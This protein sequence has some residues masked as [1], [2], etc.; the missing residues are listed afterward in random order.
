MLGARAIK[1]KI[2][3][4]YR[5]HDIY[6]VRKVAKL[7]PLKISGKW[8]VDGDGRKVI[9]RGVN[10]GHSSKVPF[11]PDGNPYI[12]ENWPPTDLENVSFVGR[13]FPREEAEEHY[14]RLKAWGFNCIRYITT[15][16]AIEHAGPYQ[17]D[18]EYLDYY[19]ELVAQAGDYGLYVFV[20]PHQ[21]VWSRVTGGDGAPLWLFEKIGLDYTKFDDAGLALNMQYLYD[22]AD[23]KSY[24][25]MVWGQNYKYFT[26]GIMWTLFFS[27][28]DFAPNLM[29]KD[30]ITGEN[31]NIQDYM[32]AHYIGCLKEIAKRVKDMPHVFGFDSLNEP[33]HGFIGHKAITRTLKLIKGSKENPPTPGLAW[34]PVDGM[35]A[36]AGHSFDLEKIGIKILKLGMGVV[37]KV[38]VNPKEISIWKE[39]AKDFWYEHGVWEEGPEGKPTAPNDDYFR[40]V[41]GKEV[42][43]TR[44]YLLPFANRVA[45]EIRKFNPNWMII[46]NDEPEKVLLSRNWPNNTPK[47]MVNGFHYYDPIHS[48]MKKVFLFKPLRLHADIFGAKLHLVWG[49]RG[50]QKMYIRHL[51]NQLELTES[52]NDGNC[53]CLVGEFGCHMDIDNGKSFKL[54]KKGKRG[55]KAFK[56]QIIRFDLLYNTF[57][58]LLLG[59]CL[60]NYCSDNTN[61]FGDKW[62]RVNR[63]IFSRSQQT[64]DW[65]DDINSGGRAIEGFCRPYARRIAGTPIRMN[66]NRKKGIF[67]LEFIPDANITAPTEIYIPPIQYPNGY[68]IRCVGAVWD[69]LEK[70]SLI[71][72]EKP[73]SDLVKLTIMR[74]N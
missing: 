14:T 34:T 3:F 1:A 73:T 28:R 27:G 54:W 6:L 22:P 70:E 55:Y 23:V 40:I 62:N 21:D 17:Y 4:G 12:K 32:F 45:D 5:I 19:A 42:N 58:E 64:A 71:L 47:N 26:N 9:L 11:K 20:D 8:L 51:K 66:F 41:N 2:L 53:P 49:L 29:V 48:I 38:R 36:A 65:R 35:F 7:S 15:W 50:I 56:W 69:E 46:V 63:S 67:N 37:G 61:E 59:S 39:G 43:F 24:Q 68:E 30:E 60:W 44:D 10:L 57:D 16:E 74:K 72:L 18:N 25:P 31:L 13:P 33:H 52:V